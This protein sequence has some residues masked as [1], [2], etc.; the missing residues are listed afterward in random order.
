MAS[1][2]SLM[3]F[4]LAG[5][6]AFLIILVNHIT[7]PTEVVTGPVFLG[8]AF[9]V[10]IVINLTREVIRR[11]KAAEENLKLLNDSLEQRVAE[12][13]R[14]LQHS[15]EF[16]KTVIDSLNDSV[17]IID[18]KKYAIVGVNAVFLKESGMMEDE[19]IEEHA[20][21]LPMIVTMSA[22]H[23]TI[24]V[25]CGDGRFRKAGNGRA[26]PL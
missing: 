2:D 15:Q 26:C 22:A 25:P 3:F 12:R 16:L 7:F 8:G 13:T 24:F 11:V 21:R 4:F 9:F 1:H 5:Y 19:I 6:L 10:F 23:R 14:E 18:V 20:M 17:A